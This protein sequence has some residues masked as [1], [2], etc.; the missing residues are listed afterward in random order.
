[1][2]RIPFT[3]YCSGP[4]VE[5]KKHMLA[6]LVQSL[7]QRGLRV[8]VLRQRADARATGSDDTLVAAGAVAHLDLCAG[9]YCDRAR[10]W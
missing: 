3:I 8:G 4:Q 1:M 9:T 10:R 2:D 7:T 6:R 5:G